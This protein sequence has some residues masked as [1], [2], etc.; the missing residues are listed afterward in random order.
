M[1]LM[2]L[3]K[4]GGFNGHH[5]HDREIASIVSEQNK[6]E[7]DQTLLGRLRS[8]WT[9]KQQEFYTRIGSRKTGKNGRHFSFKNRGT[10]T[11]ICGI[12]AMKRCTKTLTMMF[13]AE[14]S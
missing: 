2:K 14:K 7:W 10:S 13:L 3:R 5:Y 11:R 1:D 8:K 9:R 4:R 12:N 6:T